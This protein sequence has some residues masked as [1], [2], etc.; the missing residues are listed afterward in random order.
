MPTHDYVFS[1][2]TAE[3]AA[4]DLEVAVVLAAHRAAA[5]DLRDPRLAPA[6]LLRG[7]WRG[8][9]TAWLGA[10]GHDERILAGLSDEA[11]DRLLESAAQSY[12]AVVRQ[13]IA[14]VSDE[15]LAALPERLRAT[16]GD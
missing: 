3:S 1:S 12:A 10:Y 13:H 4:D 11:R 8:F 16:R 14:P 15:A 7:D 6:E 2:C 9:L 5:A